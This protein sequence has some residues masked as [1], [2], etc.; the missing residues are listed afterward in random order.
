M[1][2][3]AVSINQS[4]GQPAPQRETP[5]LLSVQGLHRGGELGWCTQLRDNWRLRR[6]L[7]LLVLGRPG[8]IGGDSAA[9]L[10]REVPSSTL[11]T[12]QPTLP[13]AAGRPSDQAGT[14]PRNASVGVP[15]EGAEPKTG[16]TREYRGGMG[17]PSFPLT[18]PLLGHLPHSGDIQDGGETF[19]EW[20][21][22][23]E[24]IAKL[25]TSHPT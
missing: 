25:Y 19:V 4:L 24:N 12:P 17:V 7:F 14:T 18:M 15:S 9:E 20:F 8:G 6:F 11:N 16:D 13:T 3:W 22:Q 5:G 23:Y 1:R 10:R 2:G 21:E